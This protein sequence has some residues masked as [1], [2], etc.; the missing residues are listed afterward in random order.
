MQK[1]IKNALHVVAA[2]FYEDYSKKT[3]LGF[4]SG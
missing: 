2:L 3:L 4:S 1:Y